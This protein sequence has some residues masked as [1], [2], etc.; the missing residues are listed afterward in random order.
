MTDTS[1]DTT[2]TTSTDSS[3]AT[4][5][6]SIS[7]A[8]TSSDTSA[9]STS[10]S[11]TDS[12]TASTDSS[13]TDAS[14]DDSTSNSSTDTST[15]TVTTVLAQLKAAYPAQYYCSYD[16]PCAW[17]NMW[18]YSS[19]D[20]LPAAS[21]LYAMTSAEWATK[22]GDT[23]TSSMYVDTT[24]NTLVTYTPPAVVISLKDQATTALATARTTVYNN[25]GILNETTPDAW[26]TYL[27]SLMAISNGT[28]T[29]STSLPTE[30]S[31]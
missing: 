1:T 4:V 24:T 30:P 8:S 18:I 31:V 3:T 22:G 28:D 16:K 27:K 25:Y 19:L 5:T 12:S 29:T 7:D 2:N 13:T 11:S 23:G 15:S 17:Y 10:D 14:T 26:V 9:S 6:P 20:G 21:T